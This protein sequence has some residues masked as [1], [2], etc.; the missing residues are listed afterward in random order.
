MTVP[1][2]T[3][4]DTVILILTNLVRTIHIKQALYN[5]DN[6]PHLNFWRVIHGNFMDIAVIDWCKLFGSDRNSSPTHW[7]NVFPNDHQQFRTDLFA[8]LQIDETTWHSYWRE[9]KSYRDGQAAH[10]D[11]SKEKYIPHFPVLTLA[12]RSSYFYYSRVIGELHSLH[13]PLASYRHYPHDLEKYCADFAR[14]AREVSETAQAAT[15][16]IEERVR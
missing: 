14:L 1:R 7:K 6:A 5:A 4:L 12:L 2:I 9:M 10:Y 16:G 13:P 11:F 3:L 8:R 15:A